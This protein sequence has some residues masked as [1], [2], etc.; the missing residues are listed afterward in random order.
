MDSDDEF[1][2]FD[3]ASETSEGD[4]EFVMG[5]ESE[6]AAREMHREDSEEF[7]FEVMTADQ[8]VQYMVDSIKEVNT[9]IQVYIV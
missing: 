7:H 8:L 2:A 4:D 3:D 6:A 5:M 1:G 9:V